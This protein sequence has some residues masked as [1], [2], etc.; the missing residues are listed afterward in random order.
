MPPRLADR[1]R[2]TLDFIRGS[3]KEAAKAGGFEA[4]LY[5]ELHA[6]NVEEAA[7]ALDRTEALEQACGWTE[8]EDGNCD[9]ACGH[10]FA[11]ISDPPHDWMKFCCYCGHPVVMLPLL[12]AAL[13]GD[14][15]HA[16]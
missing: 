11:M 13:S 8:N 4:A 5:Y 9:T 7:A 15:P 1:L 10:V 12:D 16:D 2:L 14:D 3:A 6:K